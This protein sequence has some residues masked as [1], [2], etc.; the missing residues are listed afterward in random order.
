MQ[1]DLSCFV[2]VKIYNDTLYTNVF[3]EYILSEPNCV[4]K[5]AFA[6]N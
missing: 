2:P 5:L 1:V 4:Y 6:F 3:Q